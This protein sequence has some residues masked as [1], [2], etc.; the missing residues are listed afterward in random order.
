MSDTIDFAQATPRSESSD[1][2]E[3]QDFAQANSLT[4]WCENGGEFQTQSVNREL[5]ISVIKNRPSSF[6]VEI[7]GVSTANKVAVGLSG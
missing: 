7:G 6:L 4:D 2:K 3:S 5:L 1:T